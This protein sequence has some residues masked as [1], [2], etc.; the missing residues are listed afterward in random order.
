MATESVDRRK[1]GRAYFS[2]EDNIKGLFIFVR[3]TE[4]FFSASILNV[5]RG[6]LHFSLN[7]EMRIFPKIGDKLR[8][9]KLEGEAALDIELNIELEVQWILDH[10]TL[11]HIGCGC[12]FIYVSK[13]GQDR[14]SDFIDSQY[15]GRQVPKPRP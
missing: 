9:V 1:H 11:D 7:K 12:E 13:A 2:I 4:I 8:L 10:E 15:V 5:S 14:L 3:E 6:G